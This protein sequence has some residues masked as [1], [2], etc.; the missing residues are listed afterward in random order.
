MKHYILFLLM[1]LFVVVSCGGE[2][3]LSPF[4]ELDEATS[5]NQLFHAQLKWAGSLKSGVSTNAVHVTLLD[6]DKAALTG[7][8]ALSAFTLTMPAMGHGTIET[9]QTIMA[10]TDSVGHFMVSGINFMMA[11][12][13]GAWVATV[14]ATVNGTTDVA[15]VTVLRPVE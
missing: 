15:T 14:A 13:A 4:P 10:H 8:V 1:S 6:K 5:V 3:S 2:E 9:D 12:D 11:G 7:N